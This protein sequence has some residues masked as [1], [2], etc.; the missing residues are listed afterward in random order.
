MQNSQFSH[1][2]DEEISQLF[3]FCGVVRAE[4]KIFDHGKQDD[5]PDHVLN[6][7]VCNKFIRNLK[8][9]FFTYYTILSLFFKIK[10]QVLLLEEGP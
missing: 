7:E 8:L 6:S 4:E 10:K 2:S 1:V 9:N 5:E 3:Q